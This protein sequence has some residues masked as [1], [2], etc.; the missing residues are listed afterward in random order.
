MLLFS[1][2]PSPQRRGGVMTD[3]NAAVLSALESRYYDIEDEC[4]VCA[5]VEEFCRKH[6]D[7][8]EAI[9]WETEAEDRAERRELRGDW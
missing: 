5:A 3:R 7:E 4:P 9:D 6:D 8:D 1:A 2:P